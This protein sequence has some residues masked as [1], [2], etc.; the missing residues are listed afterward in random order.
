MLIR[1]GQRSKNLEVVFQGS[2]VLGDIAVIAAEGGLQ[3]SLRSIQDNIR[4][5]AVYGLTEKQFIIIDNCTSAYLRVISSVFSSKKIVRDFDFSL[6]KI[7][8]ITGLC[9]GYL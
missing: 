3:I 8:E 2:R 1:S 7:A 9:F 4:E 6:R 5:I